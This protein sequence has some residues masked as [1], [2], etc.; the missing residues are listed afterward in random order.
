MA[1]RVMMLCVGKQAY[2]YSLSRSIVPPDARFAGR[3]FDQDL[4]EVCELYEDSFVKMDI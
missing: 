4:I 2:G 1:M 3:S